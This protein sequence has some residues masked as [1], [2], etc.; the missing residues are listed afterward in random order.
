MVRSDEP[1]YGTRSLDC[2]P[3][4]YRGHHR[5][6]YAF[7]RFDGAT[8]EARTLVMAGITPVTSNAVPELTRSVDIK[9]N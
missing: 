6:C 4:R 3:I 8:I 7:I 5:L 1:D 2:H 9:L